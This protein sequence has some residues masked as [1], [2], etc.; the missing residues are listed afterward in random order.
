M[1]FVEIIRRPVRL[2][3]EVI[4]GKKTISPATARDIAAALGTSPIFWLNLDAAYQLY[5]N[6]DPVSTRIAKQAESR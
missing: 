1:E 6:V 5:R 2:V 3:N 4:A